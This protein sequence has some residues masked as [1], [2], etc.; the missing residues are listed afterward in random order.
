M[1]EDQ[2]SFR[3]LEAIET[4]SEEN[5]NKTSV[6]TTTS[7][8]RTD[9]SNSDENGACGIYCH[10]ISLKTIMMIVLI[11]LFDKLL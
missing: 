3:L 4:E 10:F 1:S 7:S 11:E 5:T 2:K 6:N 9:E 8:N